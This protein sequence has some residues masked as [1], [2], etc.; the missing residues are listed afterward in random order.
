VSELIAKLNAKDADLQ[1]VTSLLESKVHETESLN[2]AMRSTGGEMEQLRVSLKN[3]E[4][5]KVSIT[6]PPHMHKLASNYVFD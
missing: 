5:A 6:P 4:D 3:L 2:A 1:R